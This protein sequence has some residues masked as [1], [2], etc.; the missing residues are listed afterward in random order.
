MSPLGSPLSNL[1]DLPLEPINYPPISPRCRAEQPLQRKSTIFGLL[2][3]TRDA[4]APGVPP[5]LTPVNTEK[6]ETHGVKTDVGAK[7]EK[8]FL[9]VKREK[10]VPP[11]ILVAPYQEYTCSTVCHP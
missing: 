9:S 10:K 6:L 7:V 2:K 3:K 5:D 8:G 11:P 4:P 1:F